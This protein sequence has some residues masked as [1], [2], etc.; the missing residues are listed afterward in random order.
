M[1]RNEMD[2]E[3]VRYLLHL[4]RE[5]SLGAAARSLRVRHTTVRRRIAR[6]EST[7]R[8]RLLQRTP[9]GLRLTAAAG[10]IVARAEEME[11]AAA[12][13]A[14][15]AAEDDTRLEG[16]LRITSTEAIG[17][18]FLSG[19]LS[20]FRAQHPAIV[21]HLL[22]DLRPLSLA[23]G[24]VDLAVR[25]N[26]TTETSAVTRRVGTLTFA[27]Y[28]TKPAAA[29]DAPELIVYAEGGAQA[30][31][32][33]LLRRYRRGHVVLRSNSS[34][35]LAGAA[36]ATEAV[37]MLP[38]LVGDATPGLVRVSDPHDAPGMEVWLV[39]HRELR[40]VARVAALWD[41]LVRAFAA[42]GVFRRR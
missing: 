36:A 31:T 27:A 14:H 32:E 23:R 4:A 26:R 19:E 25:L 17:G 9:D 28:T 29:A 24:E 35:V 1:L 5:G 2:W 40:G 8:T 20:R 41:H 11:R 38:C 21:V 6:L 16:P 10:R 39:T 22:T 7:L 12:S 3:N 18:M 42:D 34:L 30:Q 33:W 37:A 13:I 15:G